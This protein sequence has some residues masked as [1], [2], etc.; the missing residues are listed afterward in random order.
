MFLLV[1]VQYFLYCYRYIENNV[2][3]KSLKFGKL[4]GKFYHLNNINNFHSMLKKFM[5]RFNV[6][7]T[8][9]LDYYVSYFKSMKSKIDVFNTVLNSNL[10]Y[11]IA[12][13]RNKRACFERF[14]NL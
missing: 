8:K 14:V 11:R 5:I 4:Q 6:L 7:A 1:L 12:D 9:Y 10:Q 3:L 13:V 2:K